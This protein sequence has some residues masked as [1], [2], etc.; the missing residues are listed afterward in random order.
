MLLVIEK[1]KEKYFYANIDE[2]TYR[3]IALSQI[4]KIKKY[5][6]KHENNTIDIFIQKY[7]TRYIKKELNTTKKFIEITTNYI[8]SN[9]ME[10]NN[11]KDILN[12]FKKLFLYFK[13]LDFLLTPDLYIELLKI[14][15][16][17]KNDKDSRRRKFKLH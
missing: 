4:E 10:Q 3:K 1:I 12:E 14:P 15:T 6:D 11:Y 7:I 8:N 17:E 13:E 2:I 9:I 16:I 5:I